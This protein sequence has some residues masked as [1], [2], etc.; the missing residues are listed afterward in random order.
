MTDAFE[1]LRDLAHARRSVR[2]FRPDPLPQDVLH[3]VLA[4][5]QRAPSNCNTQP[6]MVH[7]VSGGAAERMRGA[8]YQVAGNRRPVPDYPFTGTYEGVHRERQVA[9]AKILY[10]AMGIDREDKAARNQAMR[11]NFRFFG[12]PHALFLFMHARFGPREA[13]DCGMYAQT[14][15]LALTARGIA[16]CAQ[17]ALGH[18]ADIVR[19]ELGI[20]ADHRLL[21]GIALG[22]EDGDHPANQARVGR[23][24]V[25]DAVT[26]HL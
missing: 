14:L 9:S 5:A 7:L 3:D 15:M 2:A 21:F 26:F 23:A 16:S 13:V 19:A 12:A 25:D 20:D 22:W 10:G 6:W 11:D 17:A 18:H 4:L 1:T 8:L 24:S